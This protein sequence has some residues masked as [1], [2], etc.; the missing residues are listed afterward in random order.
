[1]ARSLDTGAPLW[2]WS[3]KGRLIGADQR[4]VYLL[5]AD[6]TILGLSPANSSL[7]LLG[8]ASIEPNEKW[9]VGHVHP[10]NGDYI[11]VERVSGAPA[12]GTDDEYYFGPF[13]VALVELYAPTK[14]PVWPGKFAACNPRG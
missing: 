3:G 2:K 6:H 8:C 4:A 7:S 9:V 1:S 12:S 14:L 10:T 5:S 11:A 13:P